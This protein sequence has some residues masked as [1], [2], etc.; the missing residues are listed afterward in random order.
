MHERERKREG[1]K[2]GLQH[3][4]YFSFCFLFFFS[5]SAGVKEEEHEHEHEREIEIVTKMRLRCE[6]GAGEERKINHISMYISIHPGL[7]CVTRLR[8]R[9]KFHTCTLI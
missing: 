9:F 4:L 1:G 8:N 2:S 3:I 6:K 7:I 5:G